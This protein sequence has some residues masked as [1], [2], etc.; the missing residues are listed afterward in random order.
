[1]LQ[2]FDPPVEHQDGLTLA[3]HTPAEPHQPATPYTFSIVLSNATDRAVSGTLKLW[4][5]EDWRVAAQPPATL[6]LAPNTQC[7]IHAEGIPS[8]RVVTG[9]YPIHACF[10]N[11]T[12]MLH[13]IALFTAQASTKTIAPQPFA[14]G[15]N[16]VVA[17]ARCLPHAVFYAQQQKTNALGYSFEGADPAS[18]MQFHRSQQMRAGKTK[19]SL[20]F[21][22]PWKK[23]PGSAACDYR[24]SLPS[25]QPVF[26]DF[27]TA[28]RDLA[29]NEPPSDGVE[30]KVF[31]GHD[32]VFEERFSRF[33][34]A[35]N[36]ESATLDLSHD[37]GKTITLRFWIGPGPKND[38]TCD[39]CFWGD[40]TLRIGHPA[41]TA[42][43]SL[44]FADPQTNEACAKKTAGTGSPATDRCFVL[45][46]DDSSCFGVAIAPGHAG[47]LD[48]LITFANDTDALTFQ[49]I[50]CEL[51]NEHARVLN[52]TVSVHEK[53]LVVDHTLALPNTHDPITLRAT[54]RA[55]AGALKIAWKLDDA[56]RKTHTAA[57]LTK[58]GLGPALT[59]FSRV[60]MGFGAVFEKPEA[61]TLP[62]HGVRVSTRH[63]GADYENGLSLVQATDLVPDRVVCM[64][65]KNL[66]S[67]ESP[68]ETTFFYVPSNQGAFAAAR[69]YR[70][71]AGFRPAAGVSNLLGRVCLD[72]W[73]GHYRRAADD[74]QRAARYG[75]THAVFVKHD[76]QR[77]GYDYRLPDIYPPREDA[78]G[79]RLLR[80]A[81]AHAGMLF[82]PHDNYID[83][84]PDAEGFSYDHV[85]FTKSGTPYKAWLNRGHGGAQSYRWNPHAFLPFLKRNMRLMRDDFAPDAL[86]ID[87]FTSIPPW[88]FYDRSGIF[89]PR[90]ETV[91]RWR[92]AFDVAR[93]ILKPGSAMISESGHD[94]LIG[95]IDGVQADHWRPTE[96]VTH[97][98]AAERTPW[99]DMVTHNTM[100][101]FAGGL[102]NRYDPNPRHGYGSDDYLSMT[103]LGGRGPMTDGPFSRSAV[104][105]YWLLHDVCDA[106]A[107]AQFTDHAF[108][109]T[110]HQQQTTFVTDQT[111]AHVWV[112]RGSNAWSV[113]G[114]VLPQYGFYAQTPKAEAA[115]LNLHDRRVAYARTANTAFFFD[116]RPP[117]NAEH[118]APLETH[119]LSVTQ[120]AARAW[121]LLI[122]WKVLRP[123]DAGH[124]AFMHIGRAPIDDTER[125]EA[126]GDISL[127]EACVATCGVFTTTASIR[128]P[129]TAASGVYAVNY[130]VF[131]RTRRDRLS[132]YG[133]PEERRRIRAGTIELAAGKSVYHLP[134]MREHATPMIDFGEVVTDG[135]FRLITIPPKTWQV[136]PLPASR[137]FT[138]QLRLDRLGLPAQIRNVRAIDPFDVYAQ[139]PH[140]TC[141][142]NTLS[143]TM[144]AR[145][146]AYEIITE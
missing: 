116:A 40:P 74:I 67:F 57:I 53:E 19:Q 130:G 68:Y 5:N 29:P 88:D 65:E 118:D 4:M 50:T 102:A 141:A 2:G 77:W 9:L 43:Q 111:Q 139:D 39:A 54:V 71:V 97:S 13:P 70:A 112:N 37:A 93:E 143:M 8:S 104:V 25:G 3:I 92:E 33:S 123:I 94:A 126:Q 90:S 100:I 23:G 18:G 131:H 73:G 38:T 63:V 138:A 133:L 16:A 101:L 26:L 46:A 83:F 145:A 132:L 113:A 44:C 84:Y 61:F 24:V 127:P 30:F 55:E 136:I 41:E 36:W 42:A 108:G 107:R 87:V 62:Y 99:H 129:D 82:A 119:V 56:T 11:A 89:H 105:T 109:P 121:Q 134:D 125:I 6:T 28:L 7:V 31:V 15:T 86:F 103:V 59:P 14:P 75:L 146:F 10:S 12:Q 17:F 45:R 120:T 135:A 95:S 122:Q 66:F 137:P 144:D 98:R 78:E 81:T 69:A 27:S 117:R 124:V 110:I 79:F 76:W 114:K 85:V 49:G 35:R 64:P 32:A 58:L 106:L 142:S 20:A 51:L 115:V 34:A 52:S 96:W 47:L 72:Q 60:Y 1:M 128:L 80:S 48:A 140:W 21:H 91:Q 22:P